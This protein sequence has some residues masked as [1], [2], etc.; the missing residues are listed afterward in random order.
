MRVGDMILACNTESFLN[1][2]H[3]QATAIL[4]QMTGVVRFLVVNPNDEAENTS[5]PK[6]EKEEPMRKASLVPPTTEE[7]KT[8]PKKT[9]TKAPASPAVK[10]PEKNKIEL[11][12]KDK[13]LGLELVAS[14]NSIFVLNVLKNG[15]AA[16]DGTLKAGQRLL[17][18]NGVE[19]AKMNLEDALRTLTKSS[20]SGKVALAFEEASESEIKVEM[21]KKAGKGL[22]LG[23]SGRE[24]GKGVYVSEVGA[25]QDTLKI[26]DTLESVNGVNVSECDAESAVAALKAS[27]NG[28]VVIMAKRYKAK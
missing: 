22:G 24:S 27:P 16:V 4:K 10:E 25:Q 17:S 6:T 9:P 12:V 23:L 26:G 21:S 18:V 3:A 20:K 15:A 7:A 13:N 5:K 8:T 28:N 19:F 11:N 14:E 1:L 2:S